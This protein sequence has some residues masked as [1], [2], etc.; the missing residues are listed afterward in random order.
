MGL[1]IGPDIGDSISIDDA[2]VRITVTYPFKD[3]TTDPDT[4]EF[5]F[6]NGEKTTFSAQFPR[7]FSELSLSDGSLESAL[8]TLATQVAR[9]TGVHS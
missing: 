9:R 1:Q 7:D 8:M 5:L 4:G 2:G 6:N 3:D